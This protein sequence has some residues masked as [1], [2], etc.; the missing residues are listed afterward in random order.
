M[1]NGRLLVRGGKPLGIGM[2]DRLLESPCNMPRCAARSA[3]LVH[4]PGIN[5]DPL[6]DAI[7]LINLK[8]R[9]DR[10]A[11]FSEVNGPR[12]P[13]QPPTIVDAIDGQTAARPD[14][15]R[16]F[17]PAVWACAMSHLAVLG[18][19]MDLAQQS[20]LI[21]EDDAEFSPNFLRD[22]IQFRRSLSHR[23]WDALFLGWYGYHAQIPAWYGCHAY[24]LS[25]RAIAATAAHWR[26]S[27]GHC[28]STIW[29]ALRGLEVYFAEPAIIGQCAGR[30][31][32]AGV[33]RPRRF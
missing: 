31:D 13:W 20:V 9:P 22:W 25:G 21:L 17:P 7:Y 29:P 3:D 28:D 10:L 4:C 1:H 24:A 33:N 32:L 6:F 26:R 2:S 12:W 11:E 19:A 8:R 16:D 23:P 30:S 5:V 14:S 15:W 18:R 27:V